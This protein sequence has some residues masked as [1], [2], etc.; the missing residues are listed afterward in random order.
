VLADSTTLDRNRMY[1]RVSPWSA[2]IDEVLTRQCPYLRLSIHERRAWALA[3]STASD[4]NRTYTR[5]YPGSSPEGKDLHPACLILY[6]LHSWSCYNGGADEIWLWSKK[7][8]VLVYARG[9]IGSM[10]DQRL[11]SFLAAPPCP[12]MGGEV[13][14][15]G[16]S[17]LQV[18]ANP[19]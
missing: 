7:R 2:L 14:G 3:D 15:S 1:T 17:R 5:V 8:R 12:Y 19:N 13:S 16:P 10:R 4:R 11:T 18:Y 6:C 9:E